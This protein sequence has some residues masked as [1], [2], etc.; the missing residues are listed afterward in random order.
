M[1]EI[2][3]KKQTDTRN[4]EAGIYISETLNTEGNM[5]NA[6]KTEGVEEI[7]QTAPRTRE[8]GF[9]IKP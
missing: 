9:Y 8:Y 1:N 3:I 2:A 5:G 4:R 7:K 6:D